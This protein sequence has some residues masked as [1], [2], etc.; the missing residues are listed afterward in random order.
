MAR[1][2]GLPALL[3]VLSTT[4]PIIAQEAA[5]H[6]TL[7]KDNTEFAFK[8]F[9]QSIVQAPDR[10][11]MTAPTALSIDFAFLQNGAETETQGEISE[12]FEFKNLSSDQINQQSSALLQS[13]PQPTSPK[14]PP[15]KRPNRQNP[16]P[17]CCPAPAERLVLAGSLWAQPSVTFRPDFLET[18]KRFYSFHSASV[19]GRGPA[20]VKA[21]NAWAAQQTGGTLTDIID[22]WQKDDFLLVD[23]TWF[24]GT[25]LNPF[26]ENQTHP[27]EFHL[28]SGQKKEVPMMVKGGSIEYL[29]GNKFQSV[30]LPYYH[31]AMY[32]FLPDED[33]SLKE[34]EQSLTPDN[35]A[36]WTSA[37]GHH[38]GYLELPRFHSAY[39]GEV[40]AILENLGVRHAFMSNSSF[41]RAVS[42]PEGAMLTRVL[43]VVLLTVD[44]KG[45]EVVSSGVVGGVVGGVSAEPR[46]QPFRMIVNRP[47]F[48]AICDNQTQAILYMGAIIEP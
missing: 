45:T 1:N 41:T 47:F 46:P 39:R 9:R 12:A 33:S 4:L 16:P 21:V 10:N 43:Q 22:S 20:A 25:W 48:F 5:L 8:F 23:T 18:G 17:I 34:F 26:S 29:R 2:V 28:P 37:F 36:A 27:G 38:D 31:A 7:V 15:D 32:V 14:H 35:W 44:E 42:N 19:S 3:V 30:R 24:K 13:L 11:V 6:D 40:S